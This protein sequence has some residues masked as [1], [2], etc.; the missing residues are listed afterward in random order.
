M[1]LPSII[2]LYSP[3]MGS[4]K[5]TVSQVLSQEFGYT[6]VKFAGPL[7]AMTEAFLFEYGLE[8]E[9][10]PKYIEGDLKEK[11]IPGL[12]VSPRRIMQTLGYEWGQKQISED[13]WV[14]MTMTKIRQLTRAGL[15]VVVDDLRYPQE[16][17]ALR[18]RGAELVTVLR[19]GNIDTVTHRSEGLLREHPFTRVIENS[20]TIEELKAKTRSWVFSL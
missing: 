18:E 3:V 7:K 4:G 16:F 13:L 11:L 2:G 8:P 20:G 17:S 1:S 9:D 6:V 10:I 5:S 14:N 12:W 19:D 15:S